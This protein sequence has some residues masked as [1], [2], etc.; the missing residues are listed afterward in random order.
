MDNKSVDLVDFHSHILPGA[1]HGS[2]S[3]ET[4]LAQLEIASRYGQKRIIATPHFYPHRHTLNSFI[5]R[6]NSAVESMLSKK[7][8]LPEV[9][10][11]AE[12]LLCEGFERFEGIESLC[13]P[14]TKSILI[15]LPFVDFREEYCDAITSIIECGFDVIL[16]HADRYPKE[17]IE[18]LI[19]VGVS[20][21][22]LNAESLVTFF[23][24][25]HLFSWIEKGLVVALGSDIHGKN[26]KAYKQFV[27]AKSAVGEYIEFIKAKSD[28]IWNQIS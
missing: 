18:R 28:E 25:K 7:G 26:E 13:L 16:A 1:D 6:R 11:G 19:S 21:L 2:S 5:Q 10:I 3:V 23:K 14:G 8:S 22:Q 12:V 4:T 27:K 20:K 17:N 15:E 24:K 9:K